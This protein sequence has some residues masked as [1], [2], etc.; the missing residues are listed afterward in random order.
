MTADSAEH[1]H[2]VYSVHVE[3]EAQKL[4]QC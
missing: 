4:S 3:S 2:A 1:A